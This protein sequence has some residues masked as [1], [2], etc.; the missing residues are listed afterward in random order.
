MFNFLRKTAL[1]ILLAPW[2]IG[3]T[4]TISN[5]AVLN[6]NQ[7]RFPVMWNEYKAAQHGLHI[8][9][10]IAEAKTPEE[11]M[12]ATL[13]LLAFQSGYIDSTHCLMTSKTHLNWLADIID[14]HTVTLSIGDILLDT[15][16]DLQGILPYVWAT[17][18]L[19]RLSRR[20]RE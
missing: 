13:R 7:D 18:V 10:A 15:G 20:E 12:D 11:K 6:A 2:V 3:I 19:M 4:G 17:V 5:Q 16:T 14:F 1:W 9:E 8:E